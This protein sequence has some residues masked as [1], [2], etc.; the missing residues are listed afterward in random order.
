QPA[1]VPSPVFE[2]VPDAFPQG[3]TGM[4]T[5][6]VIAADLNGD[7]ADDLVLATEFGPNRVF[8]Y[9]EGRWQEG[10]KLPERTTYQLPFKGEDSEDIAVADFD[11][12]GDQDLFFVSE[13]TK[14]HELLLNDGKGTFILA[15][16]QIPKQ[17]AANAVLV[18]DFNQD[19]WP[20][21]LIGIRGQNELYLNQAGDGFELAQNKYWPNNQDHTQDLRLVDLDQ[22]GDQDIVEGIENGGN[23]LYLND[24]GRFVE[25]AEWLDLPPGIETRKVIVQDV[26]G[27]QDPDLFFCNVGW[28]PIMNP[29]NQLLLNDG[30]GKFTNATG[31]LPVDAA[32]TLDAAFLDF[33]DDGLL[34]IVTTNFVNDQK[35]KVFLAKDGKEGI[36][37]ALNNDPL[38]AIAFVGGTS[39]LPVTIV[40]RRYLYFANFKSPDV[41]LVEG[42]KE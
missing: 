33:N 29:Q 5:M 1:I 14:L 2:L 23:N 42:V 12:D 30:T 6:D 15:D 9:Q 20:D 7:G 3:V 26:D 11:Q 41:L 13:D 19:S 10:P 39:V 18:Y 25:H 40:D 24:S 37:Y 38:P 27:D 28:N 35:V 22:D 4:S 31:R 21:I 32:T 17:G 34:D 36:E 16:Q 8:L